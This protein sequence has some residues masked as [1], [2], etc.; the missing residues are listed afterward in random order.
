MH[1]FSRANKVRLLLAA[2]SLSSCSYS[3]NYRNMAPHYADG[4]QLV[5]RD[6]QTA[7]A[8]AVR[9]GEATWLLLRRVCLTD[10]GSWIGARELT[11]GVTVTYGSTGTNQV[12]KGVVSAEEVRDYDCLQF[13]NRQ[14]IDPFLFRRGSYR[15]ALDIVELPSKNAQLLG[16]LARS[17]LANVS[18]APQA[19][20]AAK[21]GT[22]L[23]DTFIQPAID[24]KSPHVK[25]EQDF[26][27]V[28]LRPA[29]NNPDVPWQTGN[30]VLLPR[31]GAQYDIDGTKKQFQIDVST[32]YLDQNANLRIGD[33]NAPKDSDRFFVNAPYIVFE[34]A[35]NWRG[36]DDADTAVSTSL[37]TAAR[38]VAETA[39]DGNLANESL[40]RLRTTYLQNS[41]LI[42]EWTQTMAMDAYSSLSDA[43]SALASQ[44]PLEKRLPALRGALSKLQAFRTQYT[45]ASKA[46]LTE[47]EDEAFAAITAKLTDSITPL[48]DEAT[49][50]ANAAAQQVASLQNE[51]R[52]AVERLNSISVIRANDSLFQPALAK[53]KESSAEE[54]RW[55]EI[56]VE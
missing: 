31:N 36:A 14:V 42:T 11:V 50:R 43:R 23:F 9:S 16:T 53:I 49:A 39:I 51:V 46:R 55:R 26:E 48:A 20:P 33:A 18:M 4:L 24:K 38:R 47:Q 5:K 3:A 44:E 21:V 41:D 25:F 52:G 7:T 19:A 6:A 45:T 2:I 27:A 54:A 10:V 15:I 40:D 35:A 37:R 34:V 8:N 13:T 22:A 30:I 29:V 1:R 56:A 28:E 17:V 12:G 32:L